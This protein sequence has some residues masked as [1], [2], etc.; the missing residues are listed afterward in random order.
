MDIA[1]AI[2]NSDPQDCQRPVTPQLL[3]QIPPLLEKMTM[4]SSLDQQSPTSAEMLLSEPTTTGQKSIVIFTVCS[5]NYLA[6]AMAMCHS[7]LDNH[8]D[9]DLVILVVDRKRPVTLSDPRVRLLWAEDIG[10]P[11]YLKCAFKYNIIELNT[12]L[13]PFTALKLLDEYKKVIYLDPDVCVFSTLISVISS[14]DQH[15]AV[16]T[17]HSLSPFPG[18]GRPSDQDL[19]RFGCFNLG[20]FAANGSADARGLL[21]WWH[22]QC[23]D[24]CYYEP[25]A[26]LG[27]DQK[28]IDLAP[29]FFNGVYIL[30]DPGLNVAFW[31]LHERRLSKSPA[32]WFVNDVS[33]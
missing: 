19:L 6:K 7:A 3:P 5:V 4:N 29:A 23:L 27:V 30:K 16:F 21:T 10:F 14:L 1:N 15:S 22:L 2:S 28:W 32:G 24:H 12:A 20:F 17:P 18:L 13:K 26:G 8:P 33:P 25:Q 11:D 9:M 31:N